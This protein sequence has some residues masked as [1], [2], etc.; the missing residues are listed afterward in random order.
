MLAY[1]DLC[2]VDD[3]RRRD[4]LKRL[5]RDVFQRGWWD[6]YSDEVAGSLVDRIWFESRA[7]KIHTFETVVVPGLAQT[8]E[9]A[10]ALIRAADPAA[11]AEQVQ[12]WI[13]VRLARQRLLTRQ[14]PLALVTILDEAVLRRRVGGAEVMRAQLDQLVKLAAQPNVDLMVLPARTGAHA[15]PDGAFELFEM[16]EPYPA[17]GYCLTP[18]GEIYVEATAVQRLISAYDRLR[19]ATLGPDETL[20]F[21]AGVARGMR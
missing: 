11:A 15:S 3:P 17:V 20:A 14:Q 21:I 1:L 13:E 4:A 2:G 7:L 8:P 18:V 5:S 9:Y 16:P 19:G 12:R 6:G 10:E